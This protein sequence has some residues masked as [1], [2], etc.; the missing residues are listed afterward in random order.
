[1]QLWP[2]FGFKETRGLTPRGK[3]WRKIL[4]IFGAELFHLSMSLSGCFSDTP[5][6]RIALQRLSECPRFVIQ[7]YTEDKKQ[8]VPAESSTEVA[9]KDESEENS[10]G[11]AFLC[12][13]MFIRSFYNNE[14]F[15]PP[16]SL[17]LSPNFTE[18]F[19]NFFFRNNYRERSEWMPSFSFT[20]GAC[21]QSVN[22]FCHDLYEPVVQLVRTVAS[23]QEE[24]DS[25]CSVWSL[26]VL[27]LHVSVFTK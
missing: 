14:S 27:Q 22:W 13:P 1:M 12:Q 3:M 21:L 24:L 15:L 7:T 8:R 2:I 4:S 11:V 25:C 10:D 18:T 17:K 9:R 23:E 26:P 20:L 19:P 5:S 16:L 6:E